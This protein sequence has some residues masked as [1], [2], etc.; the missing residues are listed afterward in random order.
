MD[1]KFQIISVQRNLLNQKKSKFNNYYTNS[2]DVLN[3]KIMNAAPILFIITKDS[4]LLSIFQHSKGKEFKFTELIDIQ[5][6][7]FQ[8]NITYLQ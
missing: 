5:M 6:G 2:R 8:L 1:K 3:V 4:K 7:W